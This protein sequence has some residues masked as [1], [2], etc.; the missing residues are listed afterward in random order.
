MRRAPWVPLRFPTT[1]YAI[2]EDPVVLEEEHFEGSQAG[3]LD[4]SSLKRGGNHY[5][6]LVHKLMWE[7]WKDLLLRNP[8]R[9]CGSLW[10]SFM[11]CHLVHMELVYQTVFDTITKAELETP[12]A[13]K[14][15]G[16]APVYTSRRFGLLQDFG[17]A[18]RG[19]GRRNHD[20]QPN[21]YRSPE[22]VWD[23]HEGRHLFYGYDPEKDKCAP[24]AHLAEMV[25]MLR[26]PPS[27]L[28]SRGGRS[29][30]FLRNENAHVDVLQGTSLGNLLTR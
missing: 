10:I 3:T 21:E 5:H 20:A 12:S 25:G 26:P 19:D 9:R 30:E 16:G 4:T 1:G 11:E 27:D 22:K 2:V 14:L 23:H 24:R 6:R 17:A 7:S 8:A 29:M 13:R 15:V 28:L 18:V